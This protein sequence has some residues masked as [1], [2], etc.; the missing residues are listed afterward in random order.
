MRRK[1]CALM[2]IPALLLTGCG[3]KSDGERAEELLTEVR[4]EYLEAAVCTGQA[5]I[6]ADYG[7]RVYTYDLT[8]SWQREGET[9][10]TIT[11][12]ENVAGTVARIAEGETVLEYD[13]VMVETGPLDAAGLSPIDAVPA[14][15]TCLRE[16]FLAECVLEDWDGETRLHL[17]SRDPNAEPGTGTETDLW[18]D[19]ESLAIVR[20]ELSDGGFTVLRCD[21]AGF[22]MT[23]PESGET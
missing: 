21:C 10:L 8:F 15:L 11:G 14:I 3:K 13:G 1:V 19:R 9:V 7:Q 6:T 5:A 16:G 18:L 22:V 20:A 23:L 17:I 4:G 12:P 2:M